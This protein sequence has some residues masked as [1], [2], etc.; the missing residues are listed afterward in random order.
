MPWT[1]LPVGPILSCWTGT[2]RHK[3]SLR[4]DVALS[5]DKRNSLPGKPRSGQWPGPT[6]PPIPPRSHWFQPCSNSESPM[7]RQ[8]A[9]VSG[10]LLVFTEILSERIFT[11]RRCV[12]LP[13]KWLLATSTEL[14]SPCPLWVTSRHFDKPAQCPLYPRKRTFGAARK[15]SAKGHKRTCLH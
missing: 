1:N 4:R 7:A 3:P 12:L 10:Y 14:R 2:E 6:Q 15:M 9:A 13:T 11:H 5:A 8:R